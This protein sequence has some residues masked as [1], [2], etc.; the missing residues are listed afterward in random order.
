VSDGA[1]SEAERAELENI[2]EELGVSL[3]D[4]KALEGDPSAPP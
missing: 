3:E 4:L 1:P 2:A